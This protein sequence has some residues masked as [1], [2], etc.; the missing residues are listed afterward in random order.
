MLNASEH[1]FTRNER[2]IKEKPW[3]RQRSTRPPVG[4]PHGDAHGGGDMRLRKGGLVPG[5]A[6]ALVLMAVAGPVQVGAQVNAPLAGA[7]ATSLQRG[8]INIT[9]SPGTPAVNGRTD[10]KS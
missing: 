2:L 8:F 10:R 5:A 1:S 7:H 3:R 9:G 4:N 6:V